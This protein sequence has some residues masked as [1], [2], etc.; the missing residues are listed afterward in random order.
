MSP[1]ADF[2]PALLRDRLGDPRGKHLNIRP[3]M[4]LG[5][6]RYAAYSSFPFTEYVST[7]SLLVLKQDLLSQAT[8]A[9]T[10]NL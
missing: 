7:K 2:P 3:H 5:A 9:K 8:R 4:R 1:D 6:K 10:H